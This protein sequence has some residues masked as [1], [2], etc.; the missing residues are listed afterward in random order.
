[1][2]YD[3]AMR[4]SRRYTSKYRHYAALY[5]LVVDTLPPC[6]TVVEVGIANGGS[7]QTWRTLLGPEARIVGI[8]LNDRALMLR[9]EGFEVHILDTGTESAWEELRRLFHG[10]VDLLVDDGGHTN[11]QQISTVV[12]GVDLVRGGGWIVLEDVHASFMREL[13]NP[14]PFSA[15]RFVNGLT[16]DLHRS[17]PRSSVAPARP[18]LAHAIDYV[19]SSTSWVGLRIA[20][21]EPDTR[22]E[23]TAGEDTSLMD[24]DHRWDSSRAMT[25]VERMPPV[26]ARLARRGVIRVRG[27]IEARRLFWRDLP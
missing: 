16:S 5:D 1:M 12:H 10:S 24:Y 6:P 2:K 9:E 19:V 17:H 3:E 26:M 13:G 20:H 23:V 7:L 14:S 21:W 15:A 27:A 22:D 18:K 25:M 4:Q 8:D 11:L